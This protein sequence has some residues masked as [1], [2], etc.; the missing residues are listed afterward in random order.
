MNRPSQWFRLIAFVLGPL[1]MSE[2][3]A[4]AEADV[5]FN[6]DVLPILAD[7]CFACHGFDNAK[8]EAGLRLDSLAGSTQ[9]LESGARA[10]VPGDLLASE[11]WKRI[12]SED[13]AVVM[14][15]PA[16]GH[17]ISPEQKATLKRW[18]EQGAQYEPHW[19]YVPPQ[20]IE[21]PTIAGV[22]QPIDRFIRA[23]LAAEGLAPAPAADR[24]SLIRRVTLDLTGLPPTLLEVDAFV[25]DRRRC[26]S[27]RR[28]PVAEFGTF[29]RAVGPLVA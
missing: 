5:R 17:R 21:P 13:P 20:A 11:L 22:N 15:P 8:R 9:V 26:V 28:R 24:V 7:Q 1:F 10:I 23:R 29:W 14:P 27:T 6:R 4:A 16:T 3:L 18:I 2:G 12:N 19:A 25:N